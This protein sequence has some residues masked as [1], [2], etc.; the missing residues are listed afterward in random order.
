VNRSGKG[1]GLTLAA[2]NAVDS[3]ALPADLA[4]GTTTTF[5]PFLSDEQPC[6]HLLR[7]RFLLVRIIS[8]R[9]KVSFP[10]PF[11]GHQS[12]TRTVSRIVTAE[13]PFGSDSTLFRTAP[14][15]PSQQKLSASSRRPANRCGP[16]SARHQRAA[17]VELYRGRAAR[18]G[19]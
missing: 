14:R 10:R 18:T 12:L 7:G 9:I 5:T 6:G 19:A 2:A 4:A 17:A 13:A 3:E 1:I 16:V 8:K 11:A 15:G